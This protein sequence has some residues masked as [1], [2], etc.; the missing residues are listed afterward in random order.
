MK[1]SEVKAL[2][3]THEIAEN[4]T[5]ITEIINLHHDKLSLAKTQAESNVDERI[6][7]EAEKQAKKL[8][9]IQLEDLL[10]EKTAELE[11]E[12]KAK[13][14]AETKK[15]EDEKA[16]HDATKLDYSNQATAEKTK[17][18]VLDLLKTKDEEGYSL[19]D[20]DAQLAL[21]GFDI[22]SIEL[23]DD[24]KFKDAKKVLGLFKSDPL[25][26]PKFGKVKTTSNDPDTPP[27]G[28]GDE[29]NPW[30]KEYRNGA[31]QN[32]IYRENPE[33]AKQLAKQ[34]GIYLK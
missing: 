17:Q 3:A 31:E 8:A 7:V 14:D 29:K 19:S 21:R 22:S 10:K 33:R 28:G 23:G 5:L 13:L 2:L 25:L 26:A 16:S 30:L 4:K 11:T 9:E 1:Q 24:G 20:S 6:K 32:R 27:A 15:Y 12:W 34:A 18:Q